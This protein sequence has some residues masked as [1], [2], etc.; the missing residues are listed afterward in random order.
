MPS[1]KKGAISGQTQDVLRRR[2]ERHVA[3]Q[4]PGRCARIIVRFRGPFAYVDALEP[5]AFRR[6]GVVSPDQDDGI[7][8][9]RLR[10]LGHPDRWQFAFYKYSDETYEPSVGFTGSFVVTPEEAFDCAA[11][12]YLS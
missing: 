12:A 10:Y 5:A 7:H 2:L 8:L 3:E 6:L 11:L 4:Y 9:F 1:E